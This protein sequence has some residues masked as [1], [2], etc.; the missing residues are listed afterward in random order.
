[1]DEVKEKLARLNLPKRFSCWPVLI[2]VNGVSDGLQ[3][4]EYFVKIIDFTDFLN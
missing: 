2:H 4:S 1:M 3:D